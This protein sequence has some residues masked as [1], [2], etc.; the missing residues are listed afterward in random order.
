[1][2]SRGKQILVLCLWIHAC[3]N[4]FPYVSLLALLLIWLAQ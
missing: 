2:Q 4:L 1:M 3:N